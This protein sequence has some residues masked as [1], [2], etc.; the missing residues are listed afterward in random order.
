MVLGYRIFEG[1]W[2]FFNIKR[3]RNLYERMSDKERRVYRILG[4]IL[5]FGLFSLLFSLIFLD[6][7]YSL[8]FALANILAGIT[9]QNY[10]FYLR[11]KYR[12]YS[13]WINGAF[14]KIWKK[15]CPTWLDTLIHIIISILVSGIV[16]YGFLSF[17]SQN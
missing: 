14:R 9:K 16:V 11:I 10:R 3:E 8:I 1:L 15:D 7:S 4:I 6:I 2:N 13:S 5:I 17:F 12:L